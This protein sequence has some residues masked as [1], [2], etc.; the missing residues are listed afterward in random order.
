M[1]RRISGQKS[2]ELARGYRKLNSEKFVT[3]IGNIYYLC[4]QIENNEMRGICSMK[5]SRY[6]T[7]VK[8]SVGKLKGRRPL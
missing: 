1:M 4:S 2:R 5:D 8:T 6:E 7:Q 3:F